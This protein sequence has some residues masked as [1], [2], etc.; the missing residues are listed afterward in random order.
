MVEIIRKIAVYV[1]KYEKFE[2]GSI[3]KKKLIS[4]IKEN[5]NKKE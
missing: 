5:K 1:K 2:S 3:I 4:K